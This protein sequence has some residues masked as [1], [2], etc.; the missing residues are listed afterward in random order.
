MGGPEDEEP[1][2]LIRSNPED[3]TTMFKGSTIQLVFDERIVTRSIET[4]LILTPKPPGTFRARVNKNL[5]L[6]TFTEPFDDNTTYSLSFG[7]TIQDITNN[8]AAKGINL[9]FSTGEYIDSLSIQG[10]ILNLYNQ[11]PIEN[12][13]VSLYPS[14]DSLDILSGP[15]SYYSRT[16]SAGQYKFRNLPSGD[17]RLYAVRDKN[18]NSQADSDTESYGFY[19]DTLSL[20]S[21]LENIDFTIQ[22]LNTT[23]LRTV[24]ARGFGVY[25]DI[26]FNKPIIDFYANDSSNFVYNQPEPSKIRLYPVEGPTSDTTRLIFSVKDS[27][28]TLLT[29]TAAVYFPESKIS[30]P[31]FS[32]NIT[33]SSDQLPPQDTIRLLFNKPVYQFNSDSIYL[34]LDSINTLSIDPATYTWNDTRTALIFPIDI[35]SILDKAQSKSANL[36]FGKSTFISADQDTSVAQSKTISLLTIDDSA[37]IGGKVQS[38]NPNM[39]VIVQLLDATSLK[40]LRSSTTKNFMYSYLPA[41]RY[42][43]RVIN[44]LNGNGKWD[45]GNVLTWKSPEPS[46]FYYDEF[47]KTKVIEVR[48]NWEQTDIN[49]FF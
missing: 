10:K 39:Q 30:R 27:L 16:D 33:P 8:N 37:T 24:S 19:Q 47:Y 25:F 11:E 34:Q 13:L 36:M 22:N 31:S 1:P 23:A 38:G 35:I 43:I 7:S 18:N 42:M 6:L 44:D 46:K 45:I 17:F 40:V 2:K 29:D 4:D 26:L 12:L 5:L 41:G 48:K 32:L 49:I 14:Q 20:N 28:N 21:S 3:G 15:A 9:S